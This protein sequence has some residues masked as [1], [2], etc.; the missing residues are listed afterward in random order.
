MNEIVNRKK[1]KQYSNKQQIEVVHASIQHQICLFKLF[2]KKMSTKI[3]GS[4]TGNKNTVFQSQEN[5]SSLS[6]SLHAL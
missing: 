2:F 5:T 1:N 6:K 4:V 3:T